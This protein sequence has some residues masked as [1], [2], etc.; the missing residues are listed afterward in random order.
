MIFQHP[1]VLVGLVVPL[2]LLVRQQRGA[3]PR[4]PLPFDHGPPLRRSRWVWPLAAAEALPALILACAIVLAAGPQALLAPQSKR[5]MT[6]IEF[7]V[8]VSYS[9][10]A[11]FGDGSR[12][13]AS[14]QAISGFLDFRPGDAFGLTFFGNSVLH[15]APLTSDVS[16]IRCAVPFMRPERMPWWFGGTEIGKAVLAC[17][18][19]LASR[20]EGDRMIVLVSDGASQDL[21]EGREAE[22]A[23]RLKADG[24]VLYA[25]H[26]GGG[27]PPGEIVDLA[28]LSGGEVFDAADPE[29][30]KTVFARIDR[31][32]QAKL[33]KT[34]ADL[35]DDFLPTCLAGLVLT[36]LST[37]A[38]FGWRYTPW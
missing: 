17:R 37:L 3:A 38:S 8:D 25:I 24:I 7:C 9:M 18:Q 33:E 20:A 2:L 26:I 27:P 15:W 12:Y 11:P 6:N 32:Q 30:L 28:R 35:V 19:V 31:M 4:T 13:D 36:A 23:R 10:T 22:I 16:A 5:A 29:G 21:G 1:W 14:M 34:A